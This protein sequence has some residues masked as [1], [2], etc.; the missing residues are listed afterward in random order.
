[1]EEYQYPLFFKAKELTD[2]EKEKVR[3]HF[4]KRRDSGGGDCGMIEKVGD[5]I[6]KICFKEKEGTVRTELCAEVTLQFERNEDF[7]WDFVV[8]TD[9]E[10]VLQ[11]KFHAVS[12]PSGELQ[13]TVSRTNSPQTPKSFDQP[14]TSYSQ[15]SATVRR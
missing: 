1:M 4:Q 15:V 2:R 8:F 6:F 5:N 11:R 7:S 12:L 9:Q 13:L 3:R 10:R 14:S